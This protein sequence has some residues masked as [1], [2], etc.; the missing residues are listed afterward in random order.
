M[1]QSRDAIGELDLDLYNPAAGGIWGQGRSPYITDSVSDK[2]FV[3]DDVIGA[4]PPMVARRVHDPARREQ[5]AL[6]T[7]KGECVV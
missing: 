6:P 2:V 1:T 7:K 5:L 3:Y 4:P